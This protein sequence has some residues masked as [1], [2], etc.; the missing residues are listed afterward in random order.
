MAASVLPAIATAVPFGGDAATLAA[1]DVFVDPPVKELP[2]KEPSVKEPTVKE[3]A[4]QSSTYA[5][6]PEAVKIKAMFPTLPIR[7][8]L[9]APLAVLRVEAKKPDFADSEFVSFL[10]RVCPAGRQFA[11]EYDRLIPTIEVSYTYVMNDA[12]WNVYTNMLESV[13]LA[14]TVQQTLKVGDAKFDQVNDTMIA[15]GILKLGVPL[16]EI[17]TT[18]TMVQRLGLAFDFGKPYTKEEWDDLVKQCGL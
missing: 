14:Y 4:C 15:A 1:F 8:V 3:P 7:K 9:A 16:D 12:D 5:S 10:E 18:L 13:P 11:T 17:L 6:I 2:I